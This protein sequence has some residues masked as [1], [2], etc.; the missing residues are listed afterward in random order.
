MTRV[1]ERFDS[2]WEGRVMIRVWINIPDKIG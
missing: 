2:N 1:G